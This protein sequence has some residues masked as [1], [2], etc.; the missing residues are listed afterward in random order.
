[1]N[2]KNTPKTTPIRYCQYRYC[3]GPKEIPANRRIDAIYC[4]DE[5]GVLERNARKKDNV[6]KNEDLRKLNKN[7]RILN[8]LYSNGIS[9]ITKQELK[10]LGFNFKNL[11]EICLID[12]NAKVFS[13]RIFDYEIK[14]SNNQ[15][16]IKK[17]NNYEPL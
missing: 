16:L 6:V 3:P 11:T 17:I 15:Y 9:I 8:Y 5:H 10:I 13:Y 4:C 7:Y 2:T 1:M 14:I 12:N